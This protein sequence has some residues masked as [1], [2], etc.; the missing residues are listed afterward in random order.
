MKGKSLF[1]LLS[2]FRVYTVVMKR[3]SFSIGI[4]SLA[5]SS[6]LFSLVAFSIPRY[7]GPHFTV[8]RYD[9]PFITI[10][11]MPRPLFKWKFAANRS[12]CSHPKATGLS[13]VKILWN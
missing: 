12:L 6:V 1:H 4:S 5:M 9:G 13:C 10:P 2:V 8:P 7:D 11:R 3:L